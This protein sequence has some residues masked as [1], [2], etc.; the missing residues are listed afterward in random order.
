MISHQNEIGN[1]LFEK[2]W[3]DFDF[4]TNSKNQTQFISRKPTLLQL[5]FQLLF[6]YKPSKKLHI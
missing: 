6:N 4:R 1:L 2:K 3:I 5:H